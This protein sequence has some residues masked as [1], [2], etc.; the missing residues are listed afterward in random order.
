MP[1]D[2][3]IELGGIELNPMPPLYGPNN[4]ADGNDRPSNYIA[5]P[6]RACKCGLPAMLVIIGVL[7]L[8]GLVI[9]YGFL[10]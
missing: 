1:N 9:V 8:L 6:E 2:Q 10:Y 3:Y 4:V 5:R 7:I